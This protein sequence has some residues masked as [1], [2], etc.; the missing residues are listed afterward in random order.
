MKEMK[1]L[2]KQ[3]E[4][5]LLS[6]QEILRCIDESETLYQVLSKD[7]ESEQ[8]ARAWAESGALCAFC[9]FDQQGKI[10]FD[11]GIEAVKKLSVGDLS[12]VYQEYTRLYETSREDSLK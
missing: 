1:L 11:S 3:Y 10:V 2:P 6:K 12:L 8:L 5:R 4:V 9:L 7:A